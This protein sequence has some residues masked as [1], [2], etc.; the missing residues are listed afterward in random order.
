MQTERELLERPPQL[1]GCAVT[2]VGLHACADETEPGNEY[3]HERL[4]GPREVRRWLL[5][6]SGGFWWLLVA[7]FG[8]GFWWLCF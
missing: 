7:A 1:R 2:A 8:G 6:A 3:W 4:Y 5:M